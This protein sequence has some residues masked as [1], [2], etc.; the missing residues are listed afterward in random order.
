TSEEEED[1]YWD[2]KT[3]GPLPKGYSVGR[4]TVLEHLASGGMGSVYAAYDPD[5]DRR[6][7]L[8]VI[9]TNS[10]I[11]AD[12]LRWRLL[13]EAQAMARL[14]PPNVAVVHEVGTISGQVFLA[15]EYVEGGTLREWLNQ[16][17]R[18]WQE[19]VGHFIQ[20]GRGLAAAHASGLVHRD[21]K[22]DN[23]LI[24][25]DGRVRVVDFG[26]VRPRED[27]LGDRRAAT[28]S[29]PLTA[30]GTLLGTPRYMAPE[31]MRSKTP[32][33]RADQFSFCV[34]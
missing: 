31:Q 24:G 14:S 4:F 13:R 9:A 21:F 33:G 15:M 3:Q 34:A 26:L 7:A 27:S 11:G 12:D 23:V 20:A 10:S 29:T 17:A 22:P 8:K 2:V 32:D 19:V 16:R 6:V 5:L 30:V 25:E 18:T 28:L 1:A